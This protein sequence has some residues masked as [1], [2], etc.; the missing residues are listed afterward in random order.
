MT[1]DKTPSRSK[2]SK[3]CEQLDCTT[4]STGVPISVLFRRYPAESSWY[5]ITAPSYIN[6]GGPSVLPTVTASISQVEACRDMFK[7]VLSDSVLAPVFLKELPEMKRTYRSLTE[8][9]F[10]AKKF[11]SRYL[12]YKF[13]ILPFIGDL[14]KMASFGAKIRA[15][16]EFIQK[17]YGTVVRVRRA[18][19]SAGGSTPYLVYTSS[20]TTRV[21]QAL[22][23]GTAYTGGRIRVVRQYSTQDK[24]S[25][26]VDLYGA[27]AL[28][29][30]W[31]V[32]PY[33]FVVDWFFNFGEVISALQPKFQKPVAVPL[34][35]WSYVKAY[36]LIP[37]H[38]W[39]DKRKGSVMIGETSVK[40][41]KRDPAYPSASSLLG[42]GLTWARA[43]V[44][45]A[46]AIQK[47]S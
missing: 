12:A 9:G 39:C 34:D 42:D 14:R 5:Y 31:E 1:D 7:G 21:E 35:I 37:H 30:A 23:H 20:T 44:A 17:R 29:I 27:N 24:I 32:I 28:A 10:G 25:A 47:V 4:V 40:Y 8:S 13:G 41:F 38:S 2:S 26:Y 45:A 18:S 11:A 46:L 19:G 15:H 43:P 6:V 16:S 22:W 36:A 3:Q 33:S